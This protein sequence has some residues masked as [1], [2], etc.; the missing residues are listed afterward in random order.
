MS[1][2]IA[3]SFIDLRSFSF[4]MHSA[5]PFN[6]F[7]RTTTAESLMR[8]VMVET[9]AS[10]V[11]SSSTQRSAQSGTELM[12]A[13]NSPTHYPSAHNP[14]PTCVASPRMEITTS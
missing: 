5:N 12:C 4:V 2:E 7:F 10:Q 6:A 3:P 1:E 14:G 13:S 8:A 9:M 11:A